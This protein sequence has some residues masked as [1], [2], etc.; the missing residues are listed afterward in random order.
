MKI[1]KLSFLK[2]FLLVLLF[3][4]LSNRALYGT[5]NVFAYPT[6]LTFDS[7]PFSSYEKTIKL[8]G[9]NKPK[10]YISDSLH[11][12][13]GKK[14]YSN[15]LDFKRPARTIYLKIGEDEYLLFG[16]GG[17]NYNPN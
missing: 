10:Y 15:N 17:E 1:S 7:F 2:I 16:T 13:T 11:K 14:F 9:E 6:K 3:V 5:F 4:T 12:L 8:T